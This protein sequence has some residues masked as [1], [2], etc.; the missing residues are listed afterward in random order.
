MPMA[1][2]LHFK[3]GPTWST[4]PDYTCIQRHPFNVL[5]KFRIPW[6]MTARNNDLVRTGYLEWSFRLVLQERLDFENTNKTKYKTKLTRRNLEWNNYAMQYFEKKL[7]TCKLREW[8]MNNSYFF[9]EWMNQKCK[10][11]LLVAFFSF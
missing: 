4:G 6:A 10:T 8:L 3:K 1:Y 5:L 7:V 2:K 11:F 9:H